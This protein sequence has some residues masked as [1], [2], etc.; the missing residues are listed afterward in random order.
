M[1]QDHAALDA[2]DR[3]AMLVLPRCAVGRGI[4]RR[5]YFFRRAANSL[6]DGLCRK[7]ASFSPTGDEGKAA[8]FPLNARRD[9]DVRETCLKMWKLLNNQGY[10][11]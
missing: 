4:G 10:R 3:E 2:V 1:V 9:V 5:V 7:M 6:P 11:F 8:T